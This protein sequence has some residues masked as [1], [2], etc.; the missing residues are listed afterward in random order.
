MRIQSRPTNGRESA[1]EVVYGAQVWRRG[2]SLSMRIRERVET[3]GTPAYLDTVSPCCRATFNVLLGV[4][5]ESLVSYH[6]PCEYSVV[7]HTDEGKVGEKSR[8]GALSSNNRVFGRV[9]DKVNA[10]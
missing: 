2:C 7:R 4:H 1:A 9:A 5:P 8:G 6:R 10:A 3:P